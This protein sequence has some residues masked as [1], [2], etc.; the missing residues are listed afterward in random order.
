M[1]RLSNGHKCVRIGISVNL[2]RMGNNWIE[3]TLHRGWPGAS[4]IWS[5]GGRGTKWTF[6]TR[7]TWDRKAN[8]FTLKTLHYRTIG[9]CTSCLAICIFLVQVTPRVKRYLFTYPM[10][11]F[12]NIIPR[13]IILQWSRYKLKRRKY[14]NY[15]NQQGTYIFVGGL[16]HIRVQK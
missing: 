15:I 13:N 14:I 4:C 5:D 11:A 16:H 1:T 12:Y 7:T 6:S 8:I 9:R 2:P 3:W 10:W